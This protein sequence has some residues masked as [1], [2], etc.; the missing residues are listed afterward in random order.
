MFTK[1]KL[2]CGAQAKLFHL[3]QLYYSLKIDLLED[4]RA[5]LNA[6]GVD[7]NRYKVKLIKH[8]VKGTYWIADLIEPITGFY[9]DVKNTVRNKPVRIDLDN[10][11]RNYVYGLDIIMSHALFQCLVDYVERDMASCA[12]RSRWEELGEDYKSGR[13][14][15]VGLE[16]VKL[17]SDEHEEIKAIYEW[18]I[19]VGCFEDFDSDIMP[20]EIEAMGKRMSNNAQLDMA[21][22]RDRFARI[23]EY[24]MMRRLI[25]IRPSLYA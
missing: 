5:I 23:K 12:E 9:W 3:L 14:G 7:H 10:L 2:W 13:S 25:K 11:S 20:E 6:L 22:N 16:M 8:M 1:I 17:E 19:N 21:L 24:D 4:E 15:V 18:W